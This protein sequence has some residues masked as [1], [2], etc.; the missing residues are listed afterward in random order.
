[1]RVLNSVVLCRWLIRNTIALTVNHHMTPGSALKQSLLV[2]V[3]MLMKTQ[4]K[5]QKYM[6]TWLRRWPQL[7]LKGLTTCRLIETE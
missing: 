1:M 3:L 5:D 6:A 2:T 7:G 4:R